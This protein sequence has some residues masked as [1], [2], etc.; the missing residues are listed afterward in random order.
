MWLVFVDDTKQ[1]GLRKGMGQLLALAA[2]A[3]PEEVVAAYAERVGAIYDAHGVPASTELKWSNRKD[4]WFKGS[5]GAAVLTP[6]REQCLDAAAELGARAVAV[7]FD[8]GRTS[9]QGQAAESRVL[10]YLFER[11]SLMMATPDDRALMICDK[12]GG[13]HKDED[14]W[15]TRTLG[16]TSAGTDYV[17]PGSVVIPL[18]TAPSHHHPHLQLA[19]L[20]GGAITAAVAGV[21]Y[22]MDLV[23]R[24]T[25]LLHTNRW[26]TVAGSGLKLFPDDLLN[27]YHWVL[28]CDSYMRGTT[29]VT[30]PLARY[31][32]SSDDGMG[33]IGNYKSKQYSKRFGGDGQDEA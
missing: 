25:P 26:G 5:A 29:G 2:V 12:P 18:L 14:S 31:D 1:K 28:G 30:L 17:K 22:G 27:V 4:S 11:V 32:Y 21:N 23:P 15:I 9:L 8:L 19:D 3:F 13:G 20:V 6:V 33:L 7:V 24:L 10:Q 16:L